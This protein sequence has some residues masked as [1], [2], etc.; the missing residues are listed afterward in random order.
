M[1]NQE[2]PSGF[3]RLAGKAGF[4]KARLATSTGFNLVCELA[5]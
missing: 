3:F 5:P 4:S 1:G 2:G